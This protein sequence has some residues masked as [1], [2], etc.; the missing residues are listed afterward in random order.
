MSSTINDNYD[1]IFDSYIYTIFSL[2]IVNN[3]ANY[4]M[5]LHWYFKE[6]KDI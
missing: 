5:F 6:K 3:S 1:Y 2:T 4:F